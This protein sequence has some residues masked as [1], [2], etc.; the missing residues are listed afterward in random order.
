M[1]KIHEFGVK[2]KYYDTYKRFKED[3]GKLGIRYV[4]GFTPFIFSESQYLSCIW[5]SKGFDNCKYR[6]IGMALSNPENSSSKIIDLDKEYDEALQYV[7]EWY[8][9]YK[10]K[11]RV[12]N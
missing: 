2:S 7:K 10:P 8:E 11:K 3:A 6:G 5:F 12:K 1:A 9:L 4:R